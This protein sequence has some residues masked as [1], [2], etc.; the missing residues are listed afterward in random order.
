MSHLDAA[1]F[2]AMPLPVLG[3]VSAEERHRLGEGRE[4][5][6]GEETET[7][8][9]GEDGIACSRGRKAVSA[10]AMQLCTCRHAGIQDG[11]AGA[12]ACC[13]GM[14]QKDWVF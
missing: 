1:S 8:L 2:R 9:T 10:L 4:R 13:T 7:L 12:H 6:G 3:V 5:A 11:G 14:P